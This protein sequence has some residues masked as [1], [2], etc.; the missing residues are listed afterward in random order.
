MPRRID[1]E[2]H[3]AIE[4]A[5]RAGVRPL[6]VMAKYGVSRSMVYKVAYQS[7]IPVKK[8]K[9]TSATDARRAARQRKLEELRLRDEEVVH[10]FNRGETL[11]AIGRAY[12]ITRERV[13]QITCRAGVKSRRSEK[14]EQ[15]EAMRA[16]LSQ[17]QMTPEEASVALGV[18]RNTIIGY[19]FRLRKKGYL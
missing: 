12:G 16:L 14:A 1:T 6:D 3:N 15:M 19:W 11:E 17:R 18:T 10:R 2:V 13:R 9:D 4:A 7:S 5:L 8:P